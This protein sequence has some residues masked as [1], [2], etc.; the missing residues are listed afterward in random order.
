MT[1]GYRG[2]AF[3][4]SEQP[5]AFAFSPNNLPP[6]ETALTAQETANIDWSLPVLSTSLTGLNQDSSMPYWYV[7]TEGPNLGMPSTAL[8][9]KLGEDHYETRAG[10]FEAISTHSPVSS[11]HLP[12]LGH[13]RYAFEGN[14]GTLE[15]SPHMIPYHYPVTGSA[16]PLGHHHFSTPSPQNPSFLDSGQHTSSDRI[17]RN[18]HREEHRP[19]PIAELWDCIYPNC[20]QKG[21]NGFKT[22]SDLNGHLRVHRVAKGNEKTGA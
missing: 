13:N 7:D 18:H 11:T 12:F 20:G 15:D 5:H 1:A 14:A 10:A 17:D 6:V 19:S 16:A 3:P 2:T 21:V 8:W 9:K 4:G 22:Q